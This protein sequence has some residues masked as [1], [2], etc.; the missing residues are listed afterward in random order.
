MLTLQTR[1]GKRKVIYA[2]S[3]SD[4]DSDVPTPVAKGRKPPRKSLKVA[5][6]DE[7]M[8]DDDDEAFRECCISYV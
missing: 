1:R 3:G 4:S 6:D 5:S 8:V 2:E 7:F